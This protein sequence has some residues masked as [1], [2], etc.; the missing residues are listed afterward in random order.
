[1]LSWVHNVRITVS[2]F[3]VGIML[4]Y[5]FEA[6]FAYFILF[7]GPSAVGFK[8]YVFIESCFVPKAITKCLL[9]IK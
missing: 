9:F 4:V 6:C 2:G 8:T 1:M 5:D 3:A 7:Y